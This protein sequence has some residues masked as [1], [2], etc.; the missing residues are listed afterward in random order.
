MCT[1]IFHEIT[2]HHVGFIETIFYH[3]PEKYIQHGNPPYYLFR[4]VNTALIYCFI[5]LNCKIYSQLY[6]AG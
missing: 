1:I 2:F 5:L 6:V 4:S 3:A